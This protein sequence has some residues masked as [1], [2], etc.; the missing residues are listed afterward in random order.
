MKGSKFTWI[1]LNHYEQVATPLSEGTLNNFARLLG[2]AF[3]NTYKYAFFVFNK[4]PSQ[5][6]AKDLAVFANLMLFKTGATKTY[7]TAREL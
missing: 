2:P 3:A 4:L 7:K 6:R 1:N 5:E